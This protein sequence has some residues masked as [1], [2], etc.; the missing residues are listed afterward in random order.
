MK[1]TKPKSANAASCCGRNWLGHSFQFATPATS[2]T[3]TE[4]DIPLSS[5]YLAGY[6]TNGVLACS[7]RLS[8]SV[9]FISMPCVILTGVLLVTGDLVRR[10]MQRAAGARRGL[11]AAMGVMTLEALFP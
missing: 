6:F 9:L 7:R 3:R 4:P 5:D 10:A 2:S 8:H 11:R 1:A